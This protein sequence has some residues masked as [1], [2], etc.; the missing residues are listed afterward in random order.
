MGAWDQHSPKA[1]IPGQAGAGRP[2]GTGSQLK[3]PVCSQGP[4]DHHTGSWEMLYKGLENGHVF[5]YYYKSN[6]THFFP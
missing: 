1:G 2:G 4:K 6:K 3:R 5:Y